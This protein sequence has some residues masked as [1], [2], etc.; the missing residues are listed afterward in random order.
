M[1]KMAMLGGLGVVMIAGVAFYA[2]AAISPAYTRVDCKVG[3]VP[4]LVKCINSNNIAL[5]QTV[6]ALVAEVDRLTLAVQSL[7]TK[8]ANFVQLGHEY[9]YHLKRRNAKCLN[10]AKENEALKPGEAA[11]VGQCHDPDTISEWYFVMK[12]TADNNPN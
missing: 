9:R 1:R 7:Q 12:G 8:P 11:R 4:D 2:G 6:K 10:D 3:A 5:E